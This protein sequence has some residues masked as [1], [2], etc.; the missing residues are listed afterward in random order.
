MKKKILVLF[1]IILI[2]IVAL[3]VG[4]KILAEHTVSFTMSAENE[5]EVTGRFIHIYDEKGKEVAGGTLSTNG[6][7][8]LQVSLKNGK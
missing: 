7:E 4:A 5:N 1:L 2:I 8:L 3:I 6:K